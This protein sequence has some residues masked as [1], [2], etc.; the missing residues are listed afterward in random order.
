MVK[1]LTE[2]RSPQRKLM[3]DNAG[4]GDHEQTSLWGIAQTAKHNKTH[5][6]RNL[7]RH[8]TP[9]MLKLAWKRLNKQSAI[10]DDDITVTQY[11]E[12]LEENLLQLAAKLKAK[13]YKTKLVK[14][15]YIPKENGKTR[16]LGIPA[17]EDKVVQRAVAMLL[18]AIYEQ[19]FLESSYGY[20][21]RRGAKDAV[22]DLTFQLQYGVYGYVAEADIKGFFDHI[23]HNMLLELL[24]QR[25]DDKA[26]LH[27]IR[28]W[29]KA[30]ILEP[31]GDIIHP[32]TGTPQG[33]IVSP[34][35]A[36]VYLHHV[37]DTWF[38]DE[39][40]PRLRGRA[41]QCR[42]A[43]DWVC[44]FQYQDDAQ[45]YHA[46][47]SKRLKRFN[48][49]VEPSKTKVLRFSRFHPSRKRTF[50]F[51]GFEFYWCNDRSGTSRVM[52]RTARKKQ[53]AAL[54]R[55]KTWV[56]SKRHLPNRVFFAALSRKLVGHYNYYYVRGNSRSVWSYYGQVIEHVFKWLNRR[57][58]RRSFNWTGFAQCLTHFSVP[59]PRVTEYK[60]LH[61]VALC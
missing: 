11:E 53:L 59:R 13:C 30:G 54:Q 51:L 7:Y 37:L 40:K 21:P 17:L 44:A 46:I 55:I 52:K 12:H 56:K 5:R 1:D 36:N 58:Q 15:H 9:G 47:L 60:R 25:I 19:D 38:K 8:L 24:A 2:V 41:I 50:C 42:Y 61:R 45:R 3:P 22:S 31:D 6:F 20:R 57:G 27:L 23:D 34:I 4:S 16:P 39:V 35:L 18:E 32:D 29:L 49:E 26:F 48:L 14:R 28:K 10:A 33:G 43:D